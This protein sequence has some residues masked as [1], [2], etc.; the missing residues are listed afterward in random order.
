M[1]LNFVNA[2]IRAGKDH[3][4][5]KKRRLIVAGVCIAG[6]VVFWSTCGPIGLIGSAILGVVAA[7][8][9]KNAFTDES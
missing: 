5:K 7:I 8:K 2:W 1:E 9:I 3:A 6:A 4:E